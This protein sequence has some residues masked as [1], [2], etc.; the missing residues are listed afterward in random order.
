MYHLM[1]TSDVVI[2]NKQLNSYTILEFPRR[3][4][5]VGLVYK[6]MLT[7]EV[8]ACFKALSLYLL[9]DRNTLVEISVMSITC[10]ALYR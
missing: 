3:N 1:V 10:L 4:M 7:R 5:A 2:F 6:W 9:E 8:V